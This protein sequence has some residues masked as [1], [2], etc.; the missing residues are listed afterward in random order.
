MYIHIYNLY[1]PVTCIALTSNNTNHYIIGLTVP[2]SPILLAESLFL[3]HHVS[4]NGLGVS[5][6]ILAPGIVN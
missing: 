4:P 3:S 1:H 5:T 6:P 2:I